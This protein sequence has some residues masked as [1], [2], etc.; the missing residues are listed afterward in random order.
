MRLGW[1]PRT[2]PGPMLTTAFQRL[3][4]LASTFHLRRLKRRAS[5]ERQRR[6]QPR[7]PRCTN[8]P[9]TRMSRLVYRESRSTRIAGHL[10]VKRHEPTTVERLTFAG[11]FRS[12]ASS[13][14]TRRTTT[15]IAR[16]PDFL[17]ATTQLEFILSTGTGPANARGG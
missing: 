11:H 4:T 15:R 1:R 3:T 2:K 8:A 14:G 10:W 16:Q 6:D 7:R 17:T 12:I 13:A 9:S 5:G